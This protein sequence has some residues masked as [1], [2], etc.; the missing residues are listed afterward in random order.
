[1]G[2]KAARA[3]GVPTGITVNHDT[4]DQDFASASLVLDALGE[5][6]AP[7]TVLAGRMDEPWLGLKT[8]RRIARG[9]APRL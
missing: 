5:P 4:V 9:A 2:L 7:A 3:A 1:M 6:T 8:L